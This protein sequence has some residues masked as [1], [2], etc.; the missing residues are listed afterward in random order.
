[1][2]T[3]DYTCTACDWRGDIMHR[4]SDDRPH[5]PTCGGELKVNVHAPMIHF[6]GDGWYCASYGSGFNLP[7]RGDND[8]PDHFDTRR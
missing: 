7:R 4:V 6:I 1:M 3:Y 8:R 2:P 5:C